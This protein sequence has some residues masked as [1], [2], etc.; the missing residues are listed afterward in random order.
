MISFTLHDTILKINNLYF[1]FQLKF[2]RCKMY[3]AIWPLFEANPR[4]PKKTC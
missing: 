2:T 3:I 4:P 1:D